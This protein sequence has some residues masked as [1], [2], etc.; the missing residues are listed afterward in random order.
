MCH[1]KC[2]IKLKLGNHRNCLEA[3]KL[4]NKINHL[5]NNKINIDSLKED[6]RIHK[7]EKRLKSE[8]HN[9]FTEKINK[10]A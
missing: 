5:E 6:S 2:V 10:I 3:T 7:T 1:K 9:V 4:E 8:S